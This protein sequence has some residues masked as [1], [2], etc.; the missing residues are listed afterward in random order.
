MKTGNSSRKTNWT[1]HLGSLLATSLIFISGSA[2]LS[3][4]D[5]FR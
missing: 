1:Q 2:F 4:I 3:L 5:A